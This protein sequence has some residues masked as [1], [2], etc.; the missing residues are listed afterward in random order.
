[1]SKPEKTLFLLDAYALIYRAHFAFS[2]N[3]RFNSKGL[4]TGVMLGF[5]NA[6]YEIIYKRKPTHIAV[7]FDPAGPTFRDEQYAAYKANRQ[8][9]PEDIKTSI[10]YVK[11]IIEGF[12]IPILEVEGFEADDIIGTFSK[13]AAEKGFEVYMMTPDKDFSQCVDEHV[14][15]Y[16]PAYMGSSV[17]ILGIPEVLEKWDINNVDQVRD[18][19]GLQGDSSDNIPGVPGV[20]PKTASKL[21]KE[22]GSI[23]NILEN[24]GQLKGRLK[25]TMEEN[26]EQAL[27]SKQLATIRIDVPLDFNEDE[28]AYEGPDKSK[29]IPIFTE[30]EFRT[31]A[32][33][34]F[35]EDTVRKSKRKQMQMDM[36]SGEEIKG[37]EEAKAPI[38][39]KGI[40]SKMHSYQLCD[41]EY[42]RKSLIKYLL[43]QREISIH[44]QTDGEEDFDADIIGIAFSYFKSEAYLVPINKENVDEILK[45]FRE[46]WESE[47]ILKIGHN[48][49][50]S[51]LMLKKH[52]FNLNGP[53]FDTMLAHYLIDSETRQTL[54][55]LSEKYLNYLTSTLD[56]LIG[57]KASKEKSMDIA[58]WTEYICEKADVIF[59]LKPKLENELKKLNI[60][61]LF[62]EVE[63]PLSE[64]LAEMEYEGVKLDP[65]ELETL[66][67]ALDSAAKNVEKEIFTV[68]GTEF[69][70]ASP[71]QLG[72]ILFEKLKL[73]DKPKKTK[74]GQYATGEEVLIKLAVEHKIASDI[75]DY[76]QYSKLKSTYVDALPEMIS[77]R[78]Q[79]IHTI[80]SQAVAATGRLSSNNPNLQNIPIRTAKGREIRRA[81]VSSDENYLLM[82]ADYSQIELRIMA[83]F[84]KDEHMINAFREGRDIHA[85]TASKIFKIPL[86]EVDANMR[87]MAKSA[88]F[89]MIY[90]ISAFGLSQ[91]LNI[92]RAEAKEII[93]AYFKE[94]SA[95][96]RYMD[97]CIAKAKKRGYVETILGRRRTLHDINS[98]NATLRGYAE[99][100]AINAPIQGSAAD[101]IKMAM[102]NIHNWLK[103]EMLKTKM[104]LQVHDELVF[105]VHISERD[106]VQEKVLKLMKNAVSL[107]V[108]MEVEYG[109]GKNWLEAH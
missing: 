25:S 36:F 105:D 104:I 23:E 7:A 73:S 40:Y 95:V 11:D 108:P 32:N 30:L 56:L 81:F 72:P 9:M 39:K 59:Q 53:F 29:L 103:E 62:E 8:A 97:E 87:R 34:I 67:V 60:T 19:L 46:I 12:N 2:R 38:P 57:K 51:M 1:M 83:S 91:N 93:E 58:V 21:V 107:E 68:A 44:I 45:E 96:K 94:F 90:G 41:T 63:L 18:I 33:R 106:V 16:K 76:R 27:L 10:P 13:K 43:L 79:K 65:N 100:N 6:L 54:N 20:G 78:D 101:I 3:P 42:M 92:S 61:S 47:G 24:T 80:Y 15:L 69:N 64:V 14:Y 4:N 35:G 52:G 82:S 86:E 71:K 109:F 17:D 66:S 77:N 102:I 74:S 70:I 50:Y 98:R 84:S 28:L 55:I 88:N 22:F 49:K 75:L 48:L 89:G 85:T 37:E 5:T 99:R 26:K 31:L